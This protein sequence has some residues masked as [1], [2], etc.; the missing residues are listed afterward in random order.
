MN[1]KKTKKRIL[2]YIF[3]M[4]RPLQ[5]HSFQSFP[6]ISMKTSGTVIFHTGP[7]LKSSGTM[8][9]NLPTDLIAL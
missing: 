8:F 2:H 3:I 4:V 5:L 1:G 6:V 7:L 9:M